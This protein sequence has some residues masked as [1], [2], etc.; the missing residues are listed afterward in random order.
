MNLNDEEVG[1]CFVYISIRVLDDILLGKL[2]GFG[3]WSLQGADGIPLSFFF[4]C[5]Y[6]NLEGQRTS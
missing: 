6:F 2:G 1:V 5:L 4:Y 3:S